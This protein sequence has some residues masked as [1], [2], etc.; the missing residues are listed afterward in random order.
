MKI[1]QIIRTYLVVLLLLLLVQGAEAT[2]NRAGEISIEQIGDCNNLTIR[3]TIT[4][5]TKVVG[6]A[7][8]RDSL[9][10]CWG[11]GICEN[12]ARTNGQGN[13][14][15]G[16]FIGNNIQKNEYVHE[17]TYPA[18]ATYRISMNDPNR[19]GGILN[20][21]WPNS[22][23]IPF[24]L[25]TTYTFLNPQFQ[26]CNSTPILLQPPVDIGC[27]G[28]PFIHNP[29]A[30]DVD[31]D[32][33]SYQLVMPLQD[34]DTPVPNYQFPDRINAGIDNQLTINEVTGDIRWDAPQRAGEYNLSM[35]IVEHRNGIPIDTVI[36]DMQITIE[37]C[38]NL[39]PEIELPFEEICVVAGE[40]IDFEV[41]ATPPASE[42]DQLV[43][44]TA[45][46]GPFTLDES[47]AVFEVMEGFNPFPLSGNLVWQTA[48]EHIS[49]Q[50]YSIVFRAVDNYLG[51]DRGL[52]TLKTVRIK[53]V[54][55]PPEEVAVVGG[56]GEAT[57]TWAQPYFC[58]NTADE[59]FRG[60]SVWRRENSRLFEIDTCVTGLEGKGYTQVAFD[61]Q[62]LNAD[63]HYEYVDT[64]LERGRT[65]C[66]RILGEFAKS[67][68]NGNHLY[69]RVESLPSDEVCV[70][71]SRDVPFITKVSVLETDS[72]NGQIEVNWSKPKVEDLDTLLNPG[73]YRYRLLRATGLTATDF[74]PVV[75]A[76]FISA[77]FALAND[78]IFIDTNLNTIE[79]AY[80]YQVEFF[81]NNE[82]EA[83]GAAAAASSVFLS[84]APTD[85]RMNLSWDANVPWSNVLYFIYRLNDISGEFEVVDSTQQI[86]YAD[87]GLMNKKEYCY[88][89]EAYGSYGIDNFVDPL[90]NFSQEVCAIA[91][92]DVPPCP[93]ILQV[94]NVC[95]V[96]EGFVAEDQFENTLTWTNPTEVCEE[97]DD[98]A[99]YR[100][101]Y[102]AIEG[103]DFKLIASI[104][105]AEE[106]TLVDKPELGIA[107]C[108]VVTAIDTFGNES[109]FSN[110]VCVDNCPIYE[111]PNTFTPND[112]GENDI[113]VPYPYRFIDRI[114][115]Q[116]FNRW[117]TVVF[118]TTHPDINWDG[119]SLKGKDLAS[120]TYFYSCKVFERRVGGVFQATEMLSGWIE[121]LR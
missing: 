53:V 108:Y 37:E 85:E 100:I 9:T 97:T 64:N 115:L 20:I 99:S 5:Y 41:I 80:R 59:Y 76:D 78:T 10:I 19:N 74:Q 22:D 4:T 8:N 121:L 36:R 14:P 43:E 102:T 11:D 12:I 46:G 96:L 73:P 60:F 72:N 95:D 29:N 104:D 75:G 79:N 68:P 40:L 103:G 81:V 52:S 92:D 44:L 83:L 118:E 87:I 47:P 23:G 35:I 33:I 15:Q 2:H 50:P 110:I 77:S 65:Y 25:Q 111:L 7:I 105:N 116:I 114:E 31:G 38:E 69:N 84:L 88:K 90:I 82:T 58:E 24:Q 62:N 13:P 54:G 57:V 109:I 98:V 117:G 48:C 3:A 34:I 28:Q 107:G 106:T 17:H 119:K 86:S 91:N 71:L 93:P 51:T 30:F 32:S 18:R 63:N 49:D 45:L 1:N 94:S 42:L 55:P 120:G 112:D 39:P 27:V 21:N 113:F 6:T 56:S 67:S 89:I 101:Y 61:V 70:Q 66:Y 16:E 26:G